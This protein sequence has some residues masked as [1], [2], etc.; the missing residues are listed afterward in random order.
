MKPLEFTL[1]LELLK[2]ATPHLQKMA[3]DTDNPF[4]DLTIE[5]VFS[6]SSLVINISRS[7]KGN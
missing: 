2:A 7:D 6:E 5:F 4:D 1:I 3:A